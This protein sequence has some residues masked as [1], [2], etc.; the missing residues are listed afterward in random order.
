MRYEDD[1]ERAQQS[2]DALHGI[3]EKAATLVCTAD[4]IPAKCKLAQLLAIGRN[5]DGLG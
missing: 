4:A 3:G 1:V 2:Y 5:V